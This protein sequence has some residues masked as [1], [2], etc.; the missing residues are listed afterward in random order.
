MFFSFFFCILL[1]CIHVSYGFPAIVKF[2]NA[3]F[4]RHCFDILF[5]IW[6][7]SN[8]CVRHF[9][10]KCYLR[11]ITRIGYFIECDGS[12]V[13]VCCSGQTIKCTMCVSVSQSIDF[14]VH[15]WMNI[16]KIKYDVCAFCVCECVCVQKNV[17]SVFLPPRSVAAEITIFFFFWISSSPTLFIVE[18]YC[19][20]DAFRKR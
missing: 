10:I 4:C 3:L 14:G 2:H 7:L 8:C 11:S 5:H 19:T 9:C 17:R 6:N 20:F 15:R 18:L 12:C 1:I 16:T 13:V